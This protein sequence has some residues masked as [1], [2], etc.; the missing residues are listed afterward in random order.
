MTPEQRKGYTQSLRENATHDDL[1]RVKEMSDAI[2]DFFLVD[3]FVAAIE[4]PDKLNAQLTSILFYG[5]FLGVEMR[6]WSTQLVDMKTRL[7]DVVDPNLNKEVAAV[8]RMIA[9]RVR[10]GQACNSASLEEWMDANHITPGDRE[11]PAS[12]DE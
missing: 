12:K 10:F 3:A 8:A 1:Q 4:G 2:G 5:V 7:A 9:D 6:E 11:V